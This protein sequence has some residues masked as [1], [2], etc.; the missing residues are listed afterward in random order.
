MQ[1]EISLIKKGI[2]LYFILLILEGALRKWT[3]PFLSTPLL[4]VR[5]PL[6]LG[7][8]YL[9]WK[10]GTLPAAKYLIGMVL[11]GVSSTIAAVLIGHG[12][13]QVAR[14]GARPLLLHF[15]MNFIIGKVF[16]K[17]DVIQLGKIALL[18]S[19]PMALLIAMQFY[20]PQ[21]S[22]VNK[23]LNEDVEGAGLSGALGY[24]RPSGTF[25]FTTGNTL[26]FSLVACYVVY[27]WMEPAQISKWLLLL[28]TAALLLAIPLSISRSLLFQV[29]LSLLF[30]LIAAAL[31]P[32]YFKQI[33]K[34][35]AAGSIA[36]LILFNISAFQTATK[37]FTSRIDN[38]DAVE[39]GLEG[40]LGDRVYGELTAPFEDIMQ[41]PYFGY[42]IGMG[43]NAGS[44]LLTG[45]REFL[46][47]E[48]EWGR[49]MGEMG[50]F[51]GLAVLLIRVFFTV[52][53]GLSCFSKL[54]SGD[55]LPWM[56]LSFGLLLMLQ[57]G[58]S[59]PTSLGFYT[60]ITGLLLASVTQPAQIYYISYQ[61]QNTQNINE[62]PSRYTI[63]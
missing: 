50:L 37:V 17:E 9:M 43:T 13:L 28:S 20:A 51:S 35:A 5:D 44:Q 58:W 27:F 57:G 32:A 25:S 36:L 45:G 46:I 16:G 21:S 11:L 63:D 55:L 62:N 22:W 6:V 26:F 39:G 33:F 1:K 2:W 15:P 59:Q 29:V 61:N 52:E 14:F 41:K 31:N 42:G 12:N 4:I 49:V 10:Q 3:L 30:S 54:R 34:I 56:L 8:L 23:G 53:L 47:A 7:L 19:I 24:F 60:L 48:G 38:A 40:T 18:I